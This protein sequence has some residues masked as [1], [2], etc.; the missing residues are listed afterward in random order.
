MI[1]RRW[2]EAI[3]ELQKLEIVDAFG[4]DFYRAT[5]R[6]VLATYRRRRLGR[7]DPHASVLLDEAERIATER[8][9]SKLNAQILQIRG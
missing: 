5:T 8:G 7:G 6:I 9:L 3:A 2:A 1:D 4:W